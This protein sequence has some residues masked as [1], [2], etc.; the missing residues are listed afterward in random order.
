MI[1]KRMKG[2]VCLLLCIGCLAATALA[3]GAETTKIPLTAVSLAGSAE[4]T[5]TYVCRIRNSPSYT[6]ADIGSMEDKTPVTVLGQWGDFYKIDCYDMTGYVAVSQVTTVDGNT[7]INCDPASPETE[8]L[9]YT[10]H[11]EALAIRHSLLALAKQQL[12]K[13]YVYGSTG[14]WGF[15][16]SGLMYYL[17]G[18]HGIALNRTASTQLSCGIVVSR[19]GMQV[20]DLVFLRTAGETYPASHVGIYAGGN[21]IIHAS[22]NG[23]IYSD[24]SEAYYAE[25][26][27]CVRRIIHNSSAELEQNPVV[28]SA[29]NMIAVNG[30]SGR[31]VGE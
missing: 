3:V 16:C 4:R 17:Y 15:D 7:Y 22:N 26:F 29:R 5:Q 31:R 21:Q 27:L 6:G 11:G 2:L 30:I 13:P 25:N 28:S 10:P 12:G 18:Q 23:V 9:P 24:L 8:V 14:T 19:E 20:G 1:L